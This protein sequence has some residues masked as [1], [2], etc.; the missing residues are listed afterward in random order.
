M[1]AG[2]PEQQRVSWKDPKDA[3]GDGEATRLGGWNSQEAFRRRACPQQAVMVA[4]VVCWG[5]CFCQRKLP[6]LLSLHHLLN[7]QR[8]SLYSSAGWDSAVCFPLGLLRGWEEWIGIFASLIK[9]QQT[10]FFATRL[11]TGEKPVRKERTIRN[12]KKQQKAA[13]C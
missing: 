9:D 11:H 1:D 2:E 8:V 12:A 3:T 13:S 6:L 4:G 7:I 10:D 5:H